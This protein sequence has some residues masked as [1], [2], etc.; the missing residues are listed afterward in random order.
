MIN[1]VVTKLIKLR[2]SSNRIEHP[3]FGHTTLFILVQF[4]TAIACSAVGTDDFDNQIGW[5]IEI[6]ISQPVEMLA[7]NEN[8]VRLAPWQVRPCLHLKRGTDYHAEVV[9]ANKKAQQ[10]Q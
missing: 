5:P 10:V 6:D 8:Y 2:F 9:K 3:I 4:V 7:G 1:S